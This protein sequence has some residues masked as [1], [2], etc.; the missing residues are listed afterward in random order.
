MVRIRWVYGLALLGCG[1]A[2]QVTLALLA[3]LAHNVWFTS[4]ALLDFRFD[5]ARVSRISNDLVL[6]DHTV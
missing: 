1:A 6:A 5:F 2:R 3:I 4:N